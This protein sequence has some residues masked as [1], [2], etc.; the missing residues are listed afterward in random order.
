MRGEL[1]LEFSTAFFGEGIVGI[2][3]ALWAVVR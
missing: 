3:L 1:G 2:L